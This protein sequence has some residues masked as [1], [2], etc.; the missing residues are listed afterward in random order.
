MTIWDLEVA[1]I[2]INVKPPL[3]SLRNMSISSDQSALSASGK[4]N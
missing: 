4:D 2:V 1:T 3:S